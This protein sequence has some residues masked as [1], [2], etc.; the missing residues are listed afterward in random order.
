MNLRPTLL[1]AFLVCGAAAHGQ[2]P[3]ASAG[4]IT[5][6]LTGY[7]VLREIP[8]SWTIARFKRIAK[9]D[10][11][12]AGQVWYVLTGTTANASPEPRSINS[13]TY[14]VRDAQGRNYKP[15]VT[16]TLYQ[17]EGTEVVHQKVPAGGSSKW[18]AF[19]L[20]PEGAQGLVLQANDLS[21]SGKHVAQLRIPDPATGLADAPPPAARAPETPKAT[22]AAVAAKPQPPSGS[23]PT[24]TAPAFFK[25]FNTLVGAQAMTRYKNGLVVSGSVLRTIKEMNG[26]QH[27]WLD[28]TGG[29]YISLAFADKGA[30]VVAKGIK[31]GDSVTARC[32]LLGGIDK[33]IMVGSC[34]LQ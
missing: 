28:A 34:T 10:P 21:F 33:Y 27:V 16:K 18:V 15:D 14:R 3:S 2:P 4:P 30:S 6:T 11:A 29:N 20:I 25:E 19:F 7:K 1:L 32:D 22:P 5:H 17:P 24:L 12:P 26:S 9:S 23:A 8:A 13:L 31:K